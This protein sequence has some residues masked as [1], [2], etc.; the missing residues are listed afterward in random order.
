MFYKTFK[1]FVHTKIQFFHPVPKASLIFDLE[2]D[3]LAK[4]QLIHILTT[5]QSK[6]CRKKTIGHEISPY[7]F[8]LQ[9]SRC[10]IT[11][12]FTFEPN[13]HTFLVQIL[14]IGLYFIKGTVYGRRPSDRY[15]P[16]FWEIKQK[17]FELSLRNKNELVGYETPHFCNTLYIEKMQLYF[18]K[19][20][21][22]IS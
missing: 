11:P 10:K 15:C 7:Q 6:I 13:L 9:R 16:D 5:K 8:L 14:N 2:K 22:L 3:P 19:T 1:G 20:L 4:K 12:F 21:N 17:V 18:L